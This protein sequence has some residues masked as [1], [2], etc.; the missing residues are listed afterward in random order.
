MNKRQIL[1][2]LLE[3]NTSFSTTQVCVA[4]L[5]A[6][7]MGAVLHFVYRKTYKGTVYSRDFNLTLMLVAVITTVVMLAIGSN[8]ALSLGM[9]GSLSIIR[10]RTA[11]KEPRDIAFL[12]W[13]IA[14]GLTCGSEMYVVGVL[15]SLVITAI[16]LLSSLELYDVTAYL[17]VLRA[18]QGVVE[19]DS[20]QALLEAETR[21]CKLRTRS[22]SPAGDEFTYELSVTRKQKPEK[23]VES[24]HNVYG[25]KLK[26]LNLVSYS[27][28]IV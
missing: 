12:F 18:E 2:Y 8:L 26:T 28:E 9:V 7:L 10:F 20:L 19:A 1:E 15:G 4:L 27:G 6:V 22:Q 23:I 5:M 14:I 24:L 3:H 16:L 11:I 21:N 17:L 25:D 13:S